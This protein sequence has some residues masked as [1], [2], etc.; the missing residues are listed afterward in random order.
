MT[1]L[2]LHHSLELFT[3]KLNVIGRTYCLHII[4]PLSHIFNTSSRVISAVKVSDHHSGNIFAVKTPGSFI[5]SYIRLRAF[6]ETKL[7]VHRQLNNVFISLEYITGVSSGISHRS[8]QQCRHTLLHVLI[9]CLE[10]A[11]A[12][13]ASSARSSST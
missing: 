10:G 3:T 11:T 5:L 7:P 6:P 9:T 13:M 12:S 2:F 8:P 1:I 4:F